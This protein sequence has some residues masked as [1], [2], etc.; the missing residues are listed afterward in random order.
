MA[1]SLDAG[2][3]VKKNFRNVSCKNGQI[4]SLFQKDEEAFARFTQDIKNN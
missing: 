1:F 3:M 4:Q 2:K